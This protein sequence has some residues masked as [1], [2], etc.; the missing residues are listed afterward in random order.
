MRN[1]CIVGLTTNLTKVW[2]IS[3]QTADKKGKDLMLLLAKEC[4]SSKLDLLTNAMTFV[5]IS[6]I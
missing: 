6:F 4:Y 5:I 1:V 2:Y 3:Q